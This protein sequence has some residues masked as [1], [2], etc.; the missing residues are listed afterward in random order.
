VK[1]VNIYCL[2]FVILFIDYLT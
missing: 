2:F 1:L